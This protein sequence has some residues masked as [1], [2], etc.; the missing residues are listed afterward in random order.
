MLLLGSD[1]SSAGSF[2]ATGRIKMSMRGC[3]GTGFVID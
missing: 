1:V 2:F 3:T